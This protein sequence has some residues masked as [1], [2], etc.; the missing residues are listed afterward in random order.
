[1]AVAG[2]F[3]ADPPPY[4][5]YHLLNTA[6]RATSVSSSIRLATVSGTTTRLKT[7]VSGVGA[8]F[9]LTP[10]GLP[11]ALLLRRGIAIP[12]IDEEQ[13]ILDILRSGNR[14]IDV[15][16]SVYSLRYYVGCR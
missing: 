8:G 6:R 14:F 3:V 2:V 4:A 7:G 12:F 9:F 16:R 1:M 5:V 15:L 11:K 13:F 10:W